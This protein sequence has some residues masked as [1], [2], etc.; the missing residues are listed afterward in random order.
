M[1]P[2]TLESLIAEA[3]E[4]ADIARQ[5]RS[6]NHDTLWTGRAVWLQY[7]LD[8]GEQIVVIPPDLAGALKD[9]CAWKS[10]W[11]H[12]HP[13]EVALAA[14]IDRMEKEEL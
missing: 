14:V 10:R 1:K 13:R 6:F 8:A 2:I 7:H 12:K 4:Q 3:R 11:T 5:S 9:W